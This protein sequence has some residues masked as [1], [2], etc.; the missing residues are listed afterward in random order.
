M[1]YSENEIN[2]LKSIAPNL[3]TIQEGGYTY[4]FIKDLILPEN[5]EPKIIDALLCPAPCP[6][7][8]SRLYFSEKI[9]G[10]PP[11]NWN[12]KL[13]AVNQNW[14]AISWQIKTPN[15][16]LSE[17]LSIHLKALKND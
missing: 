1:N 2:G 11:R 12:G 4:I 8:N 17:M 7:Y 14:F 9:E 10:C 15:L 13:R 6:G 3:S 5:C 16:T